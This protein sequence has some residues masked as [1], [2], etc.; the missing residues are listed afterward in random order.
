MTFA[1]KILET[2]CE[3]IV[4]LKNEND[5]LPFKNTDEIAVFGRCQKDF[6]KSGM[7]SGGSVHAPYSTNLIDELCELEKSGYLKVNHTVKEV[8]ELWLKDNPFDNGRGEW[9]CEPW[10]QKEMELEES[11]CKTAASTSQ[12]AVFVIGRNSGE[13]KDLVPEK[14]SWYLS[15]CE[16]DCLKK[17][18]KY[19]KNVVIVFNTCSVVD[20]A[21][22]NNPEFSGSIKSA[23]YAWMGG[24]ESGRAASHILCGLC[25]PSGKLTSTIAQDIS[26]YPGTKNF[27][28][29][30]E[31]F[32]E[33]DI[34]TGYRYFNTFAK[35]KILYPFGF[36]LSYTTFSLSI[37]GAKIN[38]QK[39]SVSVKITNTGKTSGKEVAQLYFSAPCGIL[40][41][42]ADELCAFKKTKLLAPGESETL[43][44]SFDLFQMASYDEEGQTGFESSWVLEKGEYSVYAG[45]DSIN[46]TKVD[47]NLYEKNS[48][49]VS[50]SGSL[51]IEKNTLVKKCTQA[52]AP[53]KTFMRMKNENGKLTMEKVPLSK[54]NLSERIKNN[55]PQEFKKS[56]KAINFDDVKKSPE[57]LEAFVAGLSLTELCTIVRG[58][59]MLSTKATLGIAAAYG[60]LSESL[61]NKRVPVAGCSDGPSGIRIDTGREASLMPIGTQIASSW[62]EELSEELFVFEGKE[63][64]KYE[65]DTLLGPGINI[66]RN[67]LG[68]RNFEYFSEDPF[69]TGKMAASQ[70]RGLNKGGVSGTIKHFAVNSQETCRT[71]CDSIL[72]ERALREIYLRGF[73]TAVK[74]SPVVSIMTSYNPVNGHHSPSNYDLVNTILRREW[75]YSGLVMTDWWAKMNDCVTGGESSMQNTA[76]MLRAGND[77]YMVVDNDC[78]ESNGYGDNIE[79]SLKN[80]KL[81]LAELQLCVKRILNFILN[82]PVSKRPLRPLKLTLSFAP[83]NRTSENAEIYTV[84]DEF[85]PSENTWLKVDKEETFIILG[86]YFKE[87]DNVS[88]S[89]SNIKINGEVAASID[90]R[91]TKGKTV[92]TDAGH[93]KLSAGFYRVSLVNTKPGITVEK[94][95]FKSE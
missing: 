47:F 82:A 60:G 8:Y 70:V 52:A 41:K 28:G 33:E 77:I 20:T 45:N 94:I 17:I 35:E 23:L 1:Q 72:S 86:T 85:L 29:K 90:S 26:D 42:P 27:G 69:L 12:K 16:T 48:P 13:D 64:F 66:Q 6:Y 88:Q 73:E 36:G 39:I 32:Y 14:G 58:E 81:T 18:C 78:S 31:N 74:E 87:G 5:V 25:T 67:P 54:V 71:V 11:L 51:F 92:T 49:L 9:A 61:Y 40:G 91:T 3:G 84:H 37:T 2:A 76:S 80:G 44:L 56:D 89:V 55:L 10:S 38:G 83:E 7:G 15:D 50:K 46:K 62:N 30:K 75:N 21:F 34:Y 24:M 79:E 93:V 4:L 22:I 53:E 57:L 68:G 59:G 19:Y 95:A 65:I 43:E 63:V